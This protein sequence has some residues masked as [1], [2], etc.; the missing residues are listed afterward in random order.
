MCVSVVGGWMHGVKDNTTQP[1]SHG[2]KSARSEHGGRQGSASSYRK[3]VGK[4]GC[5]GVG[6]EARRNCSI[7]VVLP[8]DYDYDCGWRRIK[9]AGKQVRLRKQRHMA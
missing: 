3:G 1:P 6:G 2:L 7:G 8:I 5:D 4:N 9:Q